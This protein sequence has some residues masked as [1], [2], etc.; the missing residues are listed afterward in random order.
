MAR[1]IWSGV[2]SFGLVSIPV[3]LY[4]ATKEHEVS[5]H[6]FQKGTGDRIRYQR[7][8]ERTGKEV[9]FGDIVKGADVGDNRYVMIEPEELDAIAPGRSR[10][11]DIHAFVDQSEIDPIYYQKT[12]YLGPGSPETAKTY[13][14]LRDAMAEADR[15]AIGTLVMR[16]KEYLT[17]IRTEGDVLVL[18]TM[19][20]ADE[21]RD[22]S[23]QLDGAA[24][25][26]KAKPQELE[27]ARQ[28]I[29]SMAGT[30]RPDDYRDTYTDRVKDLIAAKKKGDE[31]TVAE[32]APEA[33]NV[34]DLMSALRASVDAAKQGRGRTGGRARAATKSTRPAAKA[35]PAKQAA[36]AKKAATAKKTA[37]AKKAAPAKTT[38]KKTA[39]RKAS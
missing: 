21:V 24:A 37:R 13:A 9:D 20:F 33:T 7:I 17:A 38:A 15:V 32:A 31:I 16:G 29:E 23:E 14:L 19:F 36:P 11:L 18:E 5:F 10:N 39:A 1:P 8:N 27:M 6:Q 26:A 28:L 34:V 35:T 30:W 25:R 12:Y 3:G 22:P 2:I 4:T